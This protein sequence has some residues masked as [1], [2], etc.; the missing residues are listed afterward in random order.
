MGSLEETLKEQKIG[1]FGT[2]GKKLKFQNSKIA[3]KK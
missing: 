1:K 3:I 2:I